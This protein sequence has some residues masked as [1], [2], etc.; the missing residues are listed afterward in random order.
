M[1]SFELYMNPVATVGLL[2]WLTVSFIL[3][4]QY[5][6]KCPLRA[7]GPKRRG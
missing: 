5:D 4:G 3:Q 7:D 1:L 6:R 2:F